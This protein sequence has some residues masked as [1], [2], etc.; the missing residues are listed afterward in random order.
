[1]QKQSPLPAKMG[2]RH[3]IIIELEEKIK[4]VKLRR[5]AL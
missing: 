2:R 1:M 5:K 4:D 3:D